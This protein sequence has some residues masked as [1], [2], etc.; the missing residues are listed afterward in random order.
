LCRKYEGVEK[1][2][3]FNVRQL[4]ACKWW[5][6][7]MLRP[8]GNGVALL[9]GELGVEKEPKYVIYPV[10]FISYTQLI[11]FPSF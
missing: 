11:N 1:R 10:I 7:V 8:R 9:E 5:N 6:F 3:I 4:N 2:E